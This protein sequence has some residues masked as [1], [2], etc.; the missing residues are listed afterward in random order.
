MPRIGS[1]TV[2]IVVQEHGS[3]SDS[4]SEG[5]RAPLG[6]A[7][8]WE[9]SPRSWIDDLTSAPSAH[10]QHALA[11][12]GRRASPGSR[13]C[14]V[15]AFEAVTVIPSRSIGRR[16]PLLSGRDEPAGFATPRAE[17]PRRS[18]APRGAVRVPFPHA[19]GREIVFPY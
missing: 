10:E 19:G 17:R 3:S 8:G 11:G 14:P 15:F 7:P 9:A 1:D 2:T 18:R 12:G 16:A 4:T 5:A 13:P 6:E